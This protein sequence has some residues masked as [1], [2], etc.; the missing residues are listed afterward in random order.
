MLTVFSCYIEPHNPD[1]NIN[2][3]YILHIGMFY[4]YGQSFMSVWVALLE[5]WHL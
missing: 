4:T 2:V 3:L 5:T 1:L